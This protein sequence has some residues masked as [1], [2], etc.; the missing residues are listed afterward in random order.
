MKRISLVI[1]LFLTS[2]IAKAEFFTGNELK[3]H[4][5]DRSSPVSQT[6]CLAYVSGVV[7]AHTSVLVCPP[8]S[9][10]AGQ[11]EAIVKKYLNDNPAQL[12]KSGDIIVADA[13]K[14]EFPCKRK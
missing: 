13:I 9:S 10:T 8:A 3:K 12:H 4:C 14:K 11:M 2:F 1:A 7:D 5:E 6:F